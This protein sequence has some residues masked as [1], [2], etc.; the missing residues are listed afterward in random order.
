MQATFIL[1]DSFTGGMRPF[2]L[3]PRLEPA[4]SGGCG[5][6]EKHLG[7]V[8]CFSRDGWVLSWNEYSIYLLDTANQVSRARGTFG[9]ILG[10]S[11][12][13]LLPEML[14]VC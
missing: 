11:V 3:Y 4:D 6:S 1:K 10:F 13:S 2:E 14:W 7:L 5:S 12:P 9:R 8:S